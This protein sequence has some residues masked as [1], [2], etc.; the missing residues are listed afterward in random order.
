MP[1]LFSLVLLFPYEEK[2]STKT[3][4]DRIERTCP[5]KFE[6]RETMCTPKNT[7]NFLSG[8]CQ[9]QRPVDS[10]R[11]FLMFLNIFRCTK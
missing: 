3:H 5:D 9:A 8:R 7:F 4:I 6:Q 11:S 10:V 2:E 1:V